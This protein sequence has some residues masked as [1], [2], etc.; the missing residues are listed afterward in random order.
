MMTEHEKYSEDM[1]HNHDQSAH[2]HHMQAK[3]EA[4]QHGGE[5]SAHAPH[6]AQAEHKQH[7]HDHANHDAHAGHSGHAGHSEAMFARPFWI[8]LVLTIPVLVYAELFQELLGYTAPQFPGSAY[9]ELV[10]GSII[11]WYCGWVFLRGAA[12]ELRT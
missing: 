10:L 12:D 7:H 6:R 5:H 9:L 11:Y 2:Q 8:S 4:A 1:E 3:Q